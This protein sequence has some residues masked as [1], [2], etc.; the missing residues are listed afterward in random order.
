M[1][2]SRDRALGEELR[3]LGQELVADLGEVLGLP[4]V[5]LALRLGR[6]EVRLHLRVGLLLEQ[7]DDRSAERADR[8]ER[9]VGRAEVAAVADGHARRASSPCHSV[10]DERAPAAP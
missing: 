7:V 5:V 6:V 2:A 1:S 4:V 10:G 8:G 9:L 3:E